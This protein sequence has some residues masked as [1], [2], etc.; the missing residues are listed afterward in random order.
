MHVVFLK[1]HFS[2]YCK[3][4]YQNSSWLM[5]LSL[6]L[7]LFPPQTAPPPRGMQTP[8][9][10]G[11]P[12][13]PPRPFHKQRRISDSP[14]PRNSKPP[15]ECSVCVC[16]CACAHVFV[17]VC[18]LFCSLASVQV[19]C[20]FVDKQST[21][22]YSLQI[23]FVY[24]YMYVCHTSTCT[25]TCVHC[26]LVPTHCKRYAFPCFTYMYPPPLVL[27][28]IVGPVAL[29]FLHIYYRHVCARAGTRFPVGF[30]I[31]V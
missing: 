12:P 1:C 15:R 5:I 31:D 8:N 18:V 22:Q 7:S 25:C 3:L 26:T 11:G 19:L 21:H 28:A 2:L 10:N 6:S 23:H 4:L 24:M 14:S 29:H 9:H 13:L 17:C 16:V 27:K 30:K 20:L